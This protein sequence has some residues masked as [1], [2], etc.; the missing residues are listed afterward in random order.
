MSTADGRRLDPLVARGRRAVERALSDLPAGSPVVLGVSGGADSLALACLA[1][2]AA[3]RAGHRPVAVVVDHGLQDGSGAVARRAAE[4]VGGLGIAD[5]LVRR[6]EVG[7]SGGPEA[8]ARE[9]RR[10]ALETVADQRGAAAILLA[11]TRDDQAET[12]LLGLARGSGTR[13]LA[14]IAPVAGRWR[15]PL[16]ALSRAE[17]ER[18][19]VLAG[20]SW[21]DDPHNADPAYARVRVRR[22]VLPVLED[23]LGPG[24]AAALARTADQ[25]RADADLLDGLAAVLAR[26]AVRPDTTVDVEALVSAPPALRTRV[27]RV[28]LVGAGTPAGAL[29]RDHVLGCEALVTDWHG[30]DGP[31]LPG[32]V[33]VRRCAGAL[34]LVR[35]P[36]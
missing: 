11:H 5:V 8:A 12:V 22:Q 10:A 16:L 23:A 7:A 33:V 2:F 32:G 24:I 6:V 31:T 4:A 34:H 9:A 27:L 36:A 15:R 14:G 19:C 3:P 18:I 28:W 17:T 13:S 1:A 35:P 20:L 30:Q 29:T 26:T 25:S 21:W